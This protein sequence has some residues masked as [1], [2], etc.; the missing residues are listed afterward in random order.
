MPTG[1]IDEAW[2]T[3]RASGIVERM[4]LLRAAPSLLPL[5]LYLVLPP[6]AQS[7]PV[8]PTY[9]TGFRVEAEGTTRILTIERPW[10][11]G[12]PLRYALIEGGTGES[13]DLP[14]VDGVIETPVRTVVSLSSTYIAHLE[15]LDLLD[16]IVAVDRRSS[17]YSGRVRRLIDEGKVEEVGVAERLEVETVIDLSPELVIT[18]ALGREDVTLRALDRAGVPA[19][20]NA[21][22]LETTPLGRAEWVKLFGLLFGREEEATSRFEEVR[23]GYQETLD[24]LADGQRG[25][26]VLVNAPYNGSWALPAGESYMAR[27][28]ADAGADYPW[29]ETPGTGSI[30]L[31]LEE[32]FARAADAEVWVNL[33]FGWRTPRDVV[34]ADPRLASFA[35]YRSGRMYHYNRRVREDGAND[36]WESGAARPDR[37]LADLGRIFHPDLIS[38]HE[39]HYYR[40]LE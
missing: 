29:S 26:K 8:E 17:I 25:P 22:W 12:A 33:G 31:D 15:T 24:R 4:R 21:D 36:F 34:S 11:G 18:P 3:N 35:P 40:P 38:D 7:T 14:E 37:I 2:Q 10:P 28:L 27:L 16:R 39:F 6:A 13:P 20:V 30:F 23:R 32:V 5:L 19:L 1:F 9:A